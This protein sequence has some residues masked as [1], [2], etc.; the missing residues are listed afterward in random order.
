MGIDEVGR[1]LIAYSLQLFAVTQGLK[2]LF[3]STAQYS[4]S[5]CTAALPKVPMG[6]VGNTGEFGAFT[7]A[8]MS[9]KCFR[10]ISEVSGLIR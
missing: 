7:W 4:D 10:Y 6:N 9:W 5:G 3:F 8:C 2:Y 1:Y